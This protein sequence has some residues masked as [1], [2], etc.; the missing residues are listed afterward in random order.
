MH[1]A[2]SDRGV[3]FPLRAREREIEKETD[4][5]TDRERDE[6]ENGRKIRQHKRLE[7]ACSM[8]PVV[9]PSLQATSSPSSLPNYANW[10]LLSLSVQLNPFLPVNEIECLCVG[11]CE[12]PRVHFIKSLVRPLAYSSARMLEHRDL[13]A[14]PPCE[15]TRRP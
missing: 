1:S 9:V 3:A 7:M 6:W 12:R 13:R 5:Q 4:R 11:E 10:R 8:Y 15:P 14:R 2:A